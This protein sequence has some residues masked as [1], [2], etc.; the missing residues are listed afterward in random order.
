MSTS[1]KENEVIFDDFFSTQMK[2]LR[3]NEKLYF[4]TKSQIQNILKKA[5]LK[6]AS[7]KS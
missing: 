6:M 4:K 5:E 2:N 1:F 3:S 7:Y